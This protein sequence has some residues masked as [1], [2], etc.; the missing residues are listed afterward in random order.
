MVHD[1]AGRAKAVFTTFW[2]DLTLLVE[3]TESVATVWDAASRFVLVAASDNEEEPLPLVPEKMLLSG[4]EDSNTF[5]CA[6]GWVRILPFFA[7]VTKASEKDLVVDV[8]LRRAAIE[9][10]FAF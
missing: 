3:Q 8:Q 4:A 5:I 6:D 1:V 2:T 7:K 10:S 9:G